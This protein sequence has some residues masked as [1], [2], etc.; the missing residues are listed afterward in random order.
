MQSTTN[1]QKHQQFITSNGSFNHEQISSNNNNNN[2]DESVYKFDNLKKELSTS[3]I[4][5]SNH[6]QIRFTCASN[7]QDN[8]DDEL[9]SSM[10]L[11]TNPNMVNSINQQQHMVIP[12]KTHNQQQINTTEMEWNDSEIF[13]LCRELDEHDTYFSKTNT[14]ANTPTTNNLNHQINNQRPNKNEL[15]FFSDMNYSMTL[16]TN[17]SN[18][19]NN[20]QNFNFS[21]DLSDDIQLA[22]TVVPLQL[23]QNGFLSSNNQQTFILNETANNNRNSQNDSI[24][25]NLIFNGT[26]SSNLSNN[27]NS[28]NAP[29]F[30]DNNSDASNVMIAPWEFEN[31]FNQSYLQSPT[32]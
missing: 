11:I 4:N 19:N 23:E 17:T 25:R 2:K 27:A 3:L 31:D 29:I 26:Q 1:L 5:G 18:N 6:N 15:G 16:N 9:N 8:N 7:T 32:I 22:T 10:M 28:N 24:Y 14:N 21:F 30:L 20:N 13:Q 12:S